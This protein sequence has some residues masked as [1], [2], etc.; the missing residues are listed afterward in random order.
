MSYGTDIDAAYRQTGVYT[1]A[2]SSSLAQ[3]ATRDVPI[4]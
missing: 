4:P 2:S 3:C 1:A